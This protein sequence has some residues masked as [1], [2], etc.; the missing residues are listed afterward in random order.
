MGHELRPRQALPFTVPDIDRLL[1]AEF[2][3]VVADIDEGSRYVRESIRFAGVWPEDL[4]DRF[5]L[6]QMAARLRALPAGAAALFTFGDDPGGPTERFHFIPGNSI[7]FGQRT[8]PGDEDAKPSPL[9]ERCA[10]ALDC[11]VNLF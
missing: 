2:G 3:Y 5:N 10:K 7:M 4:A 11:D 8:G 1:R 6:K 9:V